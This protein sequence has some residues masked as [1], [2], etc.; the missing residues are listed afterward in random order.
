M[1][2]FAYGMQRWFLAGALLLTTSLYGL[3]EAGLPQAEPTGQSPA[4]TLNDS[5]L[6]SLEALQQALVSKEQEVAQVQQQLLAAQDEVNRQELSEQLRA[7][8]DELDE[9]RLQF[10]KF[11]VEIDLSPFIDEEEKAFDWQEELGKLLKP[12]MAELES[13]TAESRAIGEL[14]GQINDVS[15]QKD[16]AGKAVANLQHLLAASPSPALEARLQDRLTHWQRIESEAS[17]QYT[18]LDLQLQNR[19]A[20]R[21]SLL[22]ETTGYAK[23]FFR[24][25]GMNLI[26][27][28][29][30]FCLVFFGIR[31]VIHLSGRMK[32]K[33]SEKNFTTRLTALLL[34]MFSVIGGLAA[35]M[36]VFNMAGDWFMLGIIVIFLLGIGWASIN[37]LPNHI[38]TV[39]LMLNIGPVREGERLLFQGVPYRVDAL[40]FSARL[41]NPLLDGGVQ[42]LPVKAL[43]GHHSRPPGEKEEW[44]PTRAGDWVELSDGRMGRI[45][46]Q[47]PSSVQ[48][49]ELGGAQVVY[50]T[51]AFVA[52]NPRNLSTNFRITTTFGIDY[53]HQA[54][55]TTEVPERM[56]AK[57]EQAL[58]DVVGRDALK[59]V[60]VLF[61][62]AG[63]SSLDYEI[64]VDVDGKAAARVPVIRNAIQSILVDACNENRWE[65]PFTQIT[66]HQAN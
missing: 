23:N 35:M 19:I 4:R 62:C 40:S 59:N 36:L 61:H 50:P 3:G 34:Q 47:N 58:P 42:L 33:K 45:A 17:N 21:Q 30:A 8:K 6:Q 16:L 46:Y 53:K 52:L 15:E 11:A 22:D 5:N 31:G 14:R 41:V 44:F 38:E 43:V 64:H 57:L 32:R 20:Q 1:Y 39:K 13:A 29:G 12:I 27:A 54:I 9:Q 2:L 24:T 60:R 10:E 63:A 7:V 55:A 48:L 49:V 26:L 37:T 56:A 65:I 51:D 28:V 18:A 66:V 25:R